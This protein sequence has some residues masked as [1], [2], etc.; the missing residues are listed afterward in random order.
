[1]KKHR[2]R[3]IIRVLLLALA[4]VVTGMLGACN[5]PFGQTDSNAKG[6][7]AVP[8]TRTFKLYVRDNWITMPDGKKAYVFGYTDNPKGPAQVPGPPPRGQ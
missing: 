4:F 5:L 7:A 1:M 8:Q 6:G 2:G 3:V